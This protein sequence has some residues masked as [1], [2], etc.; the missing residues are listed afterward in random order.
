[1]T[2]ETANVVNL[3]AVQSGDYDPLSPAHFEH[4]QRVAKMFASSELVPQH[5]RGKLADCLIAYA[6]A[7]RTREEPLV[8]LQN[9][10]FVSGRAGWSAQYMIAKANRSGVFS[11]RINWRVEGAGENMRV[12]AFATLA[13]SGE[14]VEA[15]ASMAMAKAEGWT[16]NTKYQTMPDQMLRYRSAAMLIRLFC[17]EVM[18]GL[19]MADEVEDISVARG[20]STAIDITPGSAAASIDALLQDADHHPAPAVSDSPVVPSPAEPT[21]AVSPSVGTTGAPADVTMTPTAWLDGVRAELAK[22]E[23]LSDVAMLDAA[24]GVKAAEL[25]ATTLRNYKTAVLQ[26]RTRVGGAG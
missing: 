1:M 20:P 4:S 6:I 11:R 9:I 24:N 10:Y 13:D 8:V 7:K 23:T 22:A 12:T 16:R 14:V 3:P 5:L 25:G 17:P 21:Q 2:N 26:A 15:T 19:P 18:M